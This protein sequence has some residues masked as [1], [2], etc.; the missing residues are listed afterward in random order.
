MGSHTLQT[1]QDPILL[2]SWVFRAAF[3]TLVYSGEK[4]DYQSALP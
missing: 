2:L 1:F 3:Q 4:G